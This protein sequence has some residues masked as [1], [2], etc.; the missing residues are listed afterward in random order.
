[1]QNVRLAYVTHADVRQISKFRYSAY[2]RHVQTVPN[3]CDN[4]MLRYHGRC[5]VATFPLF[6]VPTPT[7]SK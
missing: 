5:I 6:F 7:E 3:G 2:G 1:V 4:A